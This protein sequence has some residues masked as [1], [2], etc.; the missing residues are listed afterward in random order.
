MSEQN[1]PPPFSPTQ[2]LSQWMGCTLEVRC[3]CSPRVVLLP[4]RLLRGDGD[5]R[6][7]DAVAALRCRLCHGRPAP[8]YLVAGHHRQRH[9]GAGPNWAIEVIEAPLAPLCTDIPVGL[10]HEKPKCEN[11]RKS[12]HAGLRCELEDQGP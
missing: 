10:G 1:H 4:I 11:D 5:R 8:V 3:P 6:L 7:K 12:Q 9:G 2:R